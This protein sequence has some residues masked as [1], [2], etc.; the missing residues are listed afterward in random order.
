MY[1]GAHMQEADT[2]YQV[3]SE[4]KKGEIPG[5]ASVQLVQHRLY[6]PLLV[7]PPTKIRLFG[8]PTINRLTFVNSGGV[9]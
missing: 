5:H 3:G 6:C 1:G 4:S 7:G 9:F 8:V 2:V